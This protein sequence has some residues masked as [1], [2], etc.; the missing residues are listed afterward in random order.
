MTP[1]ILQPGLLSSQPYVF[2]YEKI[3]ST[4]NIDDY[5]V[6]TLFVLRGDLKLRV[7][8]SATDLSAG[9]VVHGSGPLTVWG[10][11]EVFVVGMHEGEHHPVR[12]ETEG[13]TKTVSKPWGK[14][15]WLTGE[16]S[17]YCLKKIHINAGHQTSLQYHERKVETNVLVSGEIELVGAD[18]YLERLVA[19]CYVHVTPPTVHRIRALTDIILIE[20]STADLDDVVRLQDDAGRGDG[21]I[22][23]E[24]K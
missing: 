9:D 19:P 2:S 7:E 4:H 8:F 17:D 1:K 13:E 11:A 22:D 10:S 24:H 5:A 14:E 18:G 21:R 12:I 3:T 23:T 20:A 6:W 15:L 16:R